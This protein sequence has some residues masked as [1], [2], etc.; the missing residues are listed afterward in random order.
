MKTM[1]WLG[2]VLIALAATARA[3][4]LTLEQAVERALASDARIAE[5]RHLVDAARAMLQEA[6]GSDDLRYDV[7]A[8]VGLT[9]AVEGGFYAGGATSC[10]ATPCTPRSDLG[11]FDEGL[12]LWSSVQFRIIK[13]LYTFGKIEHYSE[14]AQG[15]VDVKRGDV[16]LQRNEV[17]M[18]VVRAYYG[19]LAARDTRLLLEDVQRRVASAERLVQRWLEEDKGEVKQSDLYALRTGK[20]LVGRYLAQ[21]RAVEKI[22]LRG[23]RLLT[24]VGADEELTLADQH[25]V[26]VPMPELGLEAL[27]ERAIANRPE[28]GQLEAGLRARRALVAAKKAE[29]RPNLYAGVV[30]SLSYAPQRDR[31]DNPYVYDPFNHVGATPVLGVQWEWASGVQPAH[32]AKAQA[33][34]DALVAKAAFAREGI[35]FEVAEAYY[36]MQGLHEAVQELE[37]GSRAGRRWMISRYADFEAGLEQASKVL[38]AFQGY[39]LAHSDYLSAVN[40]YNV[41]VKRLE[42][43]SGGVQ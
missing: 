6:L 24:D 4:T 8:F 41:Q 39:V 16:A 7:N 9:E 18:Q 12:S 43:I 23:L 25:I 27:T 22:A 21:A 26:P 33:E 40:D 5:R 36:Q 11:D 10:A 3:E 15:N 34:L 17:R 13:P 31:L 30:G 2:A 29:A 1:A 37:Q 28:M 32:V 20:A 38:E 14:A 42:V 35:P 19:Y